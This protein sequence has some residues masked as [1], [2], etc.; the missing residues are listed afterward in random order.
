MPLSRWES[1]QHLLR[2]GLLTPN[3]L[4]AAD[5]SVVAMQ[6]RN[7]LLVVE[8]AGGGVVIKQPGD[9]ATPDAATMWTEASLFWLSANDAAF[10]PLA[11]WMPRYLHYDEPQRIL[12]IEYVTPATSLA[13]HMLGAGVRPAVAAEAGQALATLHGPVSAATVD[14]PSRRLFAPLIPW[15]LTLGAPDLRYIPTSP[16]AASVVQWISGRPDI[17]A[18]LRQIR[19]GWR[20]DHIIH[21]DV[22][23]PNVLIVA[24]GTVRIIDWEIATLGDGWWDVAGLIHSMLIP[25]P[26][27]APEPLDRAL[28]RSRPIAEAFW[29]GYAAIAA[30]RRH[31]APP[32]VMAMAGARMLQTCIESAHLGAL[33]P[34]IP[35]MLDMAATLMVRPGIAA[36]RWN[37]A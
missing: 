8:W 5:L 17:V 18:S 6:S 33:A 35:A 14:G 37:W 10:A 13:E 30:A 23:A 11:R 31:D 21:G 9:P 12:T 2:I 20:G 27:A 32:V 36:Q 3:D 16:A 4:V 7:H 29:Q 24:D 19:A 28:E 22:K 1:I 25:N 34:G 26:A 15:V